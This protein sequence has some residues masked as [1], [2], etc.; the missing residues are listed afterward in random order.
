MKE[1]SAKTKE[2]SSTVF[3]ER[4]SDTTTP[5]PIYGRGWI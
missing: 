3:Q 5:K 4:K 1:L 2:N